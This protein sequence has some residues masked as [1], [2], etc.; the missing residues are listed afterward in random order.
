MNLIPEKP[1]LGVGAQFNLLRD[2][3]GIRVIGDI[4]GHYKPFK[5]LVEE[6]RTLGLY[7]IL[8]GDII[9][10]GPAIM[11]CIELAMDLELSFDG[12]VL[13]S[14]H[15][16]SLVRYV[17]GNAIN[18]V[19]HEQ[20]LKQA[21]AC[22]NGHEILLEYADMAANFPA[23]I[24]T[25]TLSIA[26]AGFDPQMLDMPYGPSMMARRADQRY[27]LIDLAIRGERDTR[28]RDAAGR[29]IRTYNW[30]SNI[31]KDMVVIIGHDTLSY[32]RPV[33]LQ[34]TGGKAYLIDTG[35]DRGGQLSHLDIPLVDG[36]PDVSAL[37]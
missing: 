2:Y 11:P 25:P 4:H 16:E 27:F 3:A 21:D 30:V 18:A 35:C 10:R 36:T 22:L 31:P 14:N 34:T 9:D 8:V 17:K 26:H 32:E 15:E 13:G 28:S 23:W 24:A 33:A 6:A 37:L 5:A 19:K 20:T 12:K 1:D 29:L 7:I